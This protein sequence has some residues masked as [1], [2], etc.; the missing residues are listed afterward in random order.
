MY[1]R[2][3]TSWF[4]RL[5][6]RSCTKI[7]ERRNGGVDV[8]LMRSTIETVAGEFGVLRPTDLASWKTLGSGTTKRAHADLGQGIRYGSCVEHS[9]A[10][11]KRERRTGSRNTNRGMDTPSCSGGEASG[12]KLV[13]RQ[14]HTLERTR[15]RGTPQPKTIRATYRTSA[16]AIAD[17]FLSSTRGSVNVP[18]YS[19]N[20]CLV[21]QQ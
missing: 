9:S 7:A 13:E 14:V 8:V 2:T 17:L 6:W 4:L 16:W 5:E 15:L 10:L 20:F 18:L 11:G 21:W 1:V 12:F 3:C 19:S